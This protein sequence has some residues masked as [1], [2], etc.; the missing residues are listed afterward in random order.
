MSYKSWKAWRDRNPE[1]AKAYNRVYSARWYKAHPEKSNDRR[2]YAYYLKEYGITP[3]LRQ[4]LW[5]E[6]GKR[7]KICGKETN[8]PQL[9][10]DHL[11]KRIRGMLC[12]TCNTTLGKYKDDPEIFKKFIEYLKSL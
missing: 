7:C 12:I 4:R 3:E 10:H 2:L 9:D 11:T 8:K 5:E 1:K 6:Q